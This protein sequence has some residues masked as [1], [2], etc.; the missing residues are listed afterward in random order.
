MIDKQRMEESE[1][2]RE[3]VMDGQAYGVLKTISKVV[4]KIQEEKENDS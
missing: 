2:Y 1:A 4:E 3:G